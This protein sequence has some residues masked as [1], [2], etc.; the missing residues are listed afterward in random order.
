M[1]TVLNA[2]A[3]GHTIK[4]ACQKAGVSTGAHYHWLANDKDGSY[5]EGYSF[6][7]R[8]RADRGEEA[9]ERRGIDG[10]DEVT[11]FTEVDEFG[12]ERVTGRKTVRKY[13]DSLLL[14]W[15]KANK[16]EKYSDKFKAE[17]TGEVT[18]ADTLAAARK[19]LQSVKGQDGSEA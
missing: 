18:V 17:I 9:I 5:T 4:E 16:P 3:D 2:I 7:L 6:A 13:S 1:D 8:I 12:Q 10:F 11:T 15:V 19:R 14:A